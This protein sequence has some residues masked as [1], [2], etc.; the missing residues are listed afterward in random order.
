MAGRCCVYPP[1]PDLPLPCLVAPTAACRGVPGGNNRG[2]KEPPHPKTVWQGKTPAAAATLL[3]PP[4]LSPCAARRSA[5]PHNRL[6]CCLSA[7][8]CELFET[9]CAQEA[10]ALPG[11]ALQSEQRGNPWW[12]PLQVN[13][14]LHR[15]VPLAS[16]KRRGAPLPGSGLAALLG[17]RRILPPCL[18][19]PP[20]PLPLSDSDMWERKGQIGARAR[21]N[22]LPSGSGQAGRALPTSGWKPCRFTLP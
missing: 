5:W 1:P 3:L 13:P 14:G 21:A 19:G 17:L 8:R 22:P 9:G 10:P 11:F 7:A 4:P 20:P 16:K 15:V 18:R 6:D 12:V 2:G